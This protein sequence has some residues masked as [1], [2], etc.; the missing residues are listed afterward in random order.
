MKCETTASH[1]GEYKSEKLPQQFHIEKDNP[2]FS[3]TIVFTRKTDVHD[4]EPLCTLAGD[5]RPEFERETRHFDLPSE[6][7]DDLYNNKWRL[8]LSPGKDDQGQPLSETLH[9]E[10]WCRVSLQHDNKSIKVWLEILDPKN[11]TYAS[12]LKST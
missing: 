7:V 1:T 10:F 4:H 2:T 5:V 9:L 8:W 12:K 6:L 3:V 11:I